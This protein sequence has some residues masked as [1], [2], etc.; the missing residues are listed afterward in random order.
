[1]LIRTFPYET[2]EFKVQPGD[3]ILILSDGLP[4]LFN[5][6]KEMYDYNR[7][8]LKLSELGAFG[9]QE[10]VNGFKDS[11]NEWRNNKLPDDDIT[12]LAIKFK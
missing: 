11:I 6:K 12:L 3:V 1:M 5:D 9:S 2:N 7:V 10:I 8:N 4:E